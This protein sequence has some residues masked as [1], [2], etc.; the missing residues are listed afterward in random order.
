MFVINRVQN[1]YKDDK[2]KNFMM[3]GVKGK[4]AWA[5]ISEACIRIWLSNKLI[6]LRYMWLWIT[7]LYMD[8]GKD[9]DCLKTN[10]KILIM[11]EK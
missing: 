2:I 11:R 6:M 1:L 8:L 7:V 9:N 5:L 4:L 3:F 10:L